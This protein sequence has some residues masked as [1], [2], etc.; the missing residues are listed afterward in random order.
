MSLNEGR[1]PVRIE[2]VESE[3]P[4]VYRLS[5]NYSNPFNPETVIHYDL[6]VGGHINISV[7]NLIGQKVVTLVGGHRPAGSYSVVWDGKDDNEKSLASGYYLY[8]M[9]ADG[10]ALTRKLI[11][12]R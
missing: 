6:P 4:T 2:G 10:I 8:R 7:F 12:M 1:I 11:L 9:E 5:H 3:P